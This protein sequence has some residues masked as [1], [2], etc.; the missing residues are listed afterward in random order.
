MHVATRDAALRP[1]AVR[2]VGV[3]VWPDASHLTAYLPVATGATCAADLRDNG[4]IAITLS[5]P[6]THETIQIKGHARAVRDAGDDERAIVERYRASFGEE[7]GVVGL[8]RHISARLGCWPAFAIDVEIV[9]VF[10]QTPGP[11]A[12]NRMARP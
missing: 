9:E 10:A 4:Q 7:L 1:S 12:G 8:P 3:K 2:G 6:I 5:R 11:G